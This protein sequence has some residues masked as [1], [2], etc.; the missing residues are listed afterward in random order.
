MAEDK[1]ADAP[2]KEIE[3]TPEMIEAGVA[4]L[5]L[6]DFEALSEE[7]ARDLVLEIYRAMREVRPIRQT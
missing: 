3:I 4:Q 6:G 7:T 5:L 2:A 1:S